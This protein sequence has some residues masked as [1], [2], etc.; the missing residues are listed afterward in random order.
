MNNPTLDRRS[1]GH[2]AAIDPYW[3]GFNQFLVF[4][5]KSEACGCTK[6]VAVRYKD[7]AI[8]GFAQARRRFD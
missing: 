6:Q 8:F 5:C 7:N 4:R 2:G 3:I 1:T